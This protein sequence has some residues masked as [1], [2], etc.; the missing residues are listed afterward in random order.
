MDII[1]IILALTIIICLASAL[2]KDLKNRNPYKKQKK[3]EL[4]EKESEQ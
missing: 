3:K 1:Q 2:I 4:Q